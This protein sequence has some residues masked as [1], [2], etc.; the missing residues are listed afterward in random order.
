MRVCVCFLLVRGCAQ[1]PGQYG[2]ENSQSLPSL[3][4]REAPGVSSAEFDALKREMQ[5]KEEAHSAEVARLEG[6]LEAAKQ[7]EIRFLEEA[8]ERAR[9]E[10]EDQKAREARIRKETK[11]EVSVQRGWYS[12]SRS[13]GGSPHS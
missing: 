13:R 1:L 8:E 4:M 7:R 6:L 11:E 12:P 10:R 9:E 3:R 2:L 5:A